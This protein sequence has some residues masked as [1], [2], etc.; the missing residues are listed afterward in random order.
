MGHILLLTKQA[1]LLE[2]KSL[3]IGIDFDGTVV[4]HK[5]PEIGEPIENCLEVLH[6]LQ[7]AGHKL[8]LHTM[9]SGD[10]L[11]QAVEYLDDEGIIFYDVNQNKTQK[12]WTSSPKVFCNIYIDDAALG[13][14]LDFP[15][16]NGRP[17]VDWYAVEELL[18]ERGV[19]S[20]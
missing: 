4:E 15:E 9:R 20:E 17:T 2:M 19:L 3:F 18:K 7:N 13:C 5:Y 1:E 14:P 8:I 12:H 11:E 16:G 6:K 10:R